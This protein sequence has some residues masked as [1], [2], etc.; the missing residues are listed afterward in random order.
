M[1]MEDPKGKITV[2]TILDQSDEAEV[3]PLEQQEVD[4]LFKTLD[5]KGGLFRPEL[6]PP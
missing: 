3:P 2:C 5:M 4:K 1:G 6:E